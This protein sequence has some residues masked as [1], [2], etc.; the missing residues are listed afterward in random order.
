MYSLVVLNVM[1]DVCSVTTC[2]S[3]NI[4]V[5]IVIMNN[6]KIRLFENEIS[7]KCPGHKYERKMMTI[8][9]LLK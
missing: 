6:K 1:Y 7:S 4:V 2:T 3:G 8:K 5:N 9:W